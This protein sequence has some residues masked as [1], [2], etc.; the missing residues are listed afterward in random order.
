MAKAYLDVYF[1]YLATLIGDIFILQLQKHKSVF[2]T[3]WYL[4]SLWHDDCRGSGKTD[5]IRKLV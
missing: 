1:I 5:A 4:S 3:V 2:Y